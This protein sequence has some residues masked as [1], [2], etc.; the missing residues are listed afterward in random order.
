MKTSLPPLTR[1]RVLAVRLLLAD[2][3]QPARSRNL[4]HRV[5]STRINA[6]GGGRR[7][8]SQKNLQQGMPTPS[9]QHTLA[10][11]SETT[12][13]THM[14]A[15]I[16]QPPLASHGLPA[17][18]IQITSHP[19]PPSSTSQHRLAPVRAVLCSCHKPHTQH[20][21]QKATPPAHHSPNSTAP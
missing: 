4:P 13:F 8:A 20:S 12:Q 6:R 17:A 3:P 16:V 5:D 18:I 7:R 11:H 15:G 19:T 21:S 2:L 10:Q 9:Q 14:H 1:V